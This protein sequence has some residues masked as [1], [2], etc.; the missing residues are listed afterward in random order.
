MPIS[1]NGIPGR[2]MI[3]AMICA[4][5]G[6][7]A[8]AG[9]ISQRVDGDIGIGTYY[10]S[11]IVRGAA[12]QITALPYGN[13]DYGRL[14]IRVDTLGIKTA[15]LGYG[16]VEITAKFSQDGYNAGMAHGLGS[17]PNSI[18]FGLGTLQTTPVGAFFIHAYHD[19]NQS[20]GNL[21]DVIYAGELDT[22]R[23]AFYPMAGAEYQSGNYVRYYYGVSS[24]QSAPGQYPAYQPGGAVNPFL[25]LMCDARLAEKYYLNLYLSRKWLGNAIQ[26][27]PIVNQGVMDSG[28][29]ALS[30]RF[31]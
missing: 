16:Y 8:R 28:F 26:S 6:G 9:E 11:H 27:S 5:S 19:I 20:G 12:D 15:Q 2:A 31:E 17:R 7:P 30:Y 24:R 29:V 1:S 10:T 13:F 23:L 14:F 4:M 18:P 21:F 25:G 3:C 22:V